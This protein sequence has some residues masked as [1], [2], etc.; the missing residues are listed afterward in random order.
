MVRTTTTPTPSASSTR[1]LTNGTV[2]VLDHE[3]AHTSTVAL[4]GYFFE[5]SV[6]NLTS[7]A[8]PATTAEPGD[9]L[10][11]T[12]RL[13]STDVPLDDLAFTDDFGAMNPAVVFAPGTLTVVR[14]LPPGADASDTDPN[15]GTN[16]AGL[17]DIRNLDLADLQSAASGVR[18]HS[19]GHD[20]ERH[21]R[22]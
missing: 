12:L 11:Y 17:I 3:D 6:A 4:Y 14:T 10:R 13:Q 18:G 9:V 5:K 2:G 21:G 7:G 1:A 20:R 15:G 22:H 16:G 19:R 8:N